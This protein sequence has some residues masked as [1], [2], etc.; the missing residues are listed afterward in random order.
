MATCGLGTSALV[1]DMAACYGTYGDK[2]NTFKL[3]ELKY[4]RGA[5]DSLCWS[6][7]NYFDLYL[8]TRKGA[9]LVFSLV[10]L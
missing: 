10:K 2:V 6:V 5:A 1:A 8:R 7:N 4:Q 9:I 3:D